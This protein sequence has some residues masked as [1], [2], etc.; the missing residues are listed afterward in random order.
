MSITLSNAKTRL[1]NFFV[2][3]ASDGDKTNALNEVVE[4]FLLRGKFV[5]TIDRVSLTAV[6]NI[7][8]LPAAYQTLERLWVADCGEVPV[9][10]KYFEFAR[11]GVGVVSDYATICPRMA[12]D[13]GDNAT[14]VR[15][16]QITSGSND[17]LAFIGLCKKRF[18]EVTQAGD[19]LVP[20]TYGALQFGLQAKNWELK[21]DDDRASVAWEKAMDELRNDLG[22]YFGEQ[23][24]GGFLGMD[25]AA[26]PNMRNFI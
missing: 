7:I 2:P 23:A 10:N 15:R 5:G 6:S 18:V 17:T 16:Y 25:A 1:A 20:S 26:A 24:M 3:G 21:A 19:L 9:R 4:R 12:L 8:S 14:P 13:L 22:E 11:G